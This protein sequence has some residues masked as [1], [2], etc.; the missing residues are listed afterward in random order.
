MTSNKITSSIFNSFISD[1][2]TFFIELL[3][4]T[5]GQHQGHN[6][7]MECSEVGLFFNESS[8]GKLIS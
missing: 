2:G 8:L 1:A 7:K 5:Q 6:I 3:L 4:Y